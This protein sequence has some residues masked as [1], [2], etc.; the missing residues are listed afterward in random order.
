M[1]P[2]GIER[3]SKPADVR[4]PDEWA[5]RSVNG[6]DVV[7]CI[8]ELAGNLAQA[9]GTV[10]SS[11]LPGAAEIAPLA[12]AEVRAGRVLPAHEAVPVYLRDDVARPKGP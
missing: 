11:I 2:V 3:V 5:G 1:T 8:W 12:V 10:D 7:C 6:L 4:L 9:L